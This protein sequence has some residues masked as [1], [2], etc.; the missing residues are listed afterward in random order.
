MQKILKFK[1]SLDYYLK[2]LD[3]RLAEHDYLGALDSA[4]NALRQSKTRIDKEAINILIGQ[5][6]FEMGQY[7]LSCEYFFRAVKVPQTRASAYFGIGRN[8]I[9][10]NREKLALEY[11]DCALST[12]GVEDFSGAILEWTHIIRQNLTI[13][14]PKFSEVAVAKNLVKLSE[15]DEALEILKPRF[16]SGEI[17]AKV[18]TAD[19]LVLKGEYSK[20][21]DILLKILRFENDN[22][23]ALLVLCSLCLAEKDYGNLEINLEQLDECELNDNQ[24]GVLASLYASIGKYEKSVK[25]YE[26]ILKNDAFNIKYLLFTAIC[27]YNLGNTQEALYYIGQ[28]RWVD[29]ENPIL[30]IYYDIFNRNLVSPPLKLVT[31]IPPAISEDKLK[32]IFSA[33]NSGNFCENFVHSLTLADDIEWCF[34]LKNNTLTE[35]LARVLAQCR[36]KQA[37]ALYSKMLLTVRLNKN[38]KFYLTKY[39]LLNNHLKSIDLTANFKYRSFKLTIPKKIEN[40]LVIKKGLCC[41]VSFAE[42]N[43]I[44][45]NFN[46]INSKLF[47]FDWVE[48]I[49]LQ[50]DENLV[51]CLY[52]CENAQVL[53][54]ACIYFA[55]D[56]ERV[57]RAINYLQL[58]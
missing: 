58:L 28:A 16:Y 15:Y 48:N 46:A 2:T 20:A 22:V 5:I 6:Y 36:K 26:K 47:K 30:N 25:N 7:I 54:Q 24:L 37:I 21:R 49:D 10:M 19:I 56:K 31:Q 40:N 51:A 34:C 1:P 39:A 9:K 57:N 42:I 32:N 35:E 27:Y 41:A 50:V 13:K 11:F 3:T 43:S 38:Q 55:T 18:I 12:G 4:R 23:S 8:L 17:E 53:E 52:F 33:I 14:S 45:V 44:T 29:I